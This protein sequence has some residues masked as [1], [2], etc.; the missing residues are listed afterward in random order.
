MEVNDVFSVH[1]RSQYTISVPMDAPDGGWRSTKVYDA[2][3]I[4]LHFQVKGC[5]RLLHLL[6]AY[7]IS[8]I[9]LRIFPLKTQ[10]ERA[11]S[12]QRAFPP[13]VQS[14]S[15]FP[16]WNSLRF[17]AEPALQIDLAL[18]KPTFFFETDPTQIQASLESAIA[19]LHKF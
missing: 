18:K 11:L 1:L 12:P 14:R 13:I 7:V 10:P 9:P 4:F 3:K 17:I 6:N 15:A 5:E 16:R 8:W 2:P 19:Q